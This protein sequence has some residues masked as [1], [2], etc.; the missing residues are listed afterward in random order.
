MAVCAIIALTPPPHPVPSH[1]PPPPPP[2]PAQY[3]PPPL[4]TPLTHV[5][6]SLRSDMEAALTDVL[7]VK[8]VWFWTSRQRDRFVRWATKI[9]E[10]R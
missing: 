7:G 2:P 4:C 8:N 10:H 9:L 3:I 1:P 6:M 5:R